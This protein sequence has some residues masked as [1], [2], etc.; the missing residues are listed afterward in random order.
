MH[1]LRLQGNCTG[2]GLVRPYPRFAQSRRPKLH[3]RRVSR[4]ACESWRL[5]TSGYVH[6]YVCARE[7]LSRYSQCALGWCAI[8]PDECNNL[9]RFVAQNRSSRPA[10]MQRAS[11]CMCIAMGMHRHRSIAMQ[12]RVRVSVT[13]VRSEWWLNSRCPIAM[14]RLSSLIGR[15]VGTPQGCALVWFWCKWF[16]VCTSEV[17][18][19]W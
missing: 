9:T 13:C 12:P 6:A 2:R 1:V 19:L 5:C 10:A 3:S 16:I 14:R 7:R 17:E 11:R 4:H 18:D 15:I 8:S